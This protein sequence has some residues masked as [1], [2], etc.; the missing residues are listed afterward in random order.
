MH[1]GAEFG[2]AAIDER[3]EVADFGADGCSD[4][5]LDRLGLVCDVPVT[6]PEKAD[7]NTQWLI[8]G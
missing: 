8:S 1:L 3:A 6:P 5:L 4:C 7:L 2:D